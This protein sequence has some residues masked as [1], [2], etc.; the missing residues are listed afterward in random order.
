M[1]V[2]D[3][4]PG[5][6]ALLDVRKELVDKLVTCRADPNVLIVKAKGRGMIGSIQASAAVVPGSESGREKAQQLV[7]QVLEAAETDD[8]K[9]EEFAQLLEENSLG[10]VAAFLREKPTGQPPVQDSHTPFREPEQRIPD[11]SYGDRPPKLEPVSLDSGVAKDL[12]QVQNGNTSPEFDRTQH[13][14]AE[15]KPSV[16]ISFEAVPGGMVY[17][18]QEHDDNL[19]VAS[20]KPVHSVADTQPHVEESS[21]MLGDRSAHILPETKSLLQTNQDLQTQL[22]VKTNNEQTLEEQLKQM[23]IEKKQNV[24][25]LAQKEKELQEKEQQIKQLKAKVSDLT[26]ELQSEKK[27]NIK[28]KTELEEKI[29][30][31]KCQLK[32]KEAKFNEEKFRL[33]DEKHKLEMKIQT[34]HTDEETLKRLILEEK[35]K[36]AEL[37]AQAEKDKTERTV[38]DLKREHEKQME[39]YVQKIENIRQEHRNSI[40]QKDQEH[41]AAIRELNSKLG[42]QMSSEPDS[43]RGDDTDRVHVLRHSHSDA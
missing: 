6:K 14:L 19:D 3:H 5:Y 25:K 11:D 43:S 18:E 1:A 38:N 31:L 15:R 20:E 29:K 21:S 8:S 4:Q 41:Q 12:S 35:C 28:V 37:H 2:A 10:E 40:S 7:N 39:N 16:G 24:E 17:V 33:I 26:Q 23:G 42:K 27:S 34:M 13:K 30:H 22:A 32:E 36:V 9:V